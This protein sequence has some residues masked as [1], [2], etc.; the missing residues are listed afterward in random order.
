MD[1]EEEESGSRG[2]PRLTMSSAQSS[3][4]S[5]FLPFF[6]LVLTNEIVPTLIYDK[7]STVVT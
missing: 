6:L 7:T 3:S 5:A 2:R 4:S 1:E